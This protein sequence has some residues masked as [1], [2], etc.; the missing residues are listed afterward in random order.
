MLRNKLL[1]QIKLRGAMYESELQ[2]LFS[3]TEDLNAASEISVELISL[4]RKGKIDLTFDHDRNRVF[5]NLDRTL[6]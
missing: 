4:V 1:K 6:N 2:K 5:F 3:K